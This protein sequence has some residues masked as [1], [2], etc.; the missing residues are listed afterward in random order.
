MSV[1]F[2]VRRGSRSTMTGTKANLVLA[3]GEI[4]LEYPDTGIGSGPCRFKVGDGTTT[5][6]ALEYAF[7][8]VDIQKNGVTVIN[9]AN[10][11][12]NIVVPTKTSE[13][14]NDSGYKTTDNNTTYDIKTAANNA[15]NGNAKI[16]LAGSDGVNDD[17]LV[18]GTG[19]TTVTTDENGNIVINSANTV[20]T[21]PNSGV[22]AELIDQFQ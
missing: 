7:S 18:K 21:H 5:Y 6:S 16:R 20:Y 15:T 4:F 1:I 19:A 10:G 17:L 12:A 8:V 13:L 22:T 11:I 3:S 9:E 14:T 2:K